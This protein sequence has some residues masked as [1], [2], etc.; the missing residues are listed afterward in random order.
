MWFKSRATLFL[1][2]FIPRILPT[3]SQ[4]PPPWLAVL[5]WKQVSHSSL[6]RPQTC[7]SSETSPW[8]SHPGTSQWPGTSRPC[9]APAH[10]SSGACTHTGPGSC[11]ER[12]HKENTK[13]T[14]VTTS[15]PAPWSRRWAETLLWSSGW[16]GASLQHKEQGMAETDQLCAETIREQLK[17]LKGRG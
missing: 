8:T 16:K 4:A 3:L 2:S 5:T 14:S 6:G 9:G 1:A 17:R 15:I 7:R 10:H 12:S 13:L 11:G